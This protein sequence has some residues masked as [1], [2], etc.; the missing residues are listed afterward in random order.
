MHSDENFGQILKFHNT[1]L[2][3]CGEI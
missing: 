1:F 3:A 2:N